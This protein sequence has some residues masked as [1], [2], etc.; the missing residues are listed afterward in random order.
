[1]SRESFFN[2]PA[3]WED[4]KQLVRTHTHFMDQI[5]QLA[6][7]RFDW[8][9]SRTRWGRQNRISLIAVGG[10][11][12]GELLPESDIDLLILLERSHHG[13]SDKIQD[14]IRFLWDL[15]L[16]VGH[17]VRTINECRTQAA[18]DVT[19]L[20]A[21]MESRTLCGDESLRAK[22]DQKIAPSRVWPSRDFFLA[23]RQ[24]QRARHRKS[25]HT[26]YSLEPNIKISPGGLRDI[27]TLGWIARRQYG[28]TTF[29][30]LAAMGVI[31]DEEA[32]ELTEG[33]W[34]LARI[35]F[36]L[37]LL[38]GRDDN[39]LLFEHQQK[40]AAVFGYEDG[41]QLAVEQFMQSYYRAAHRINAISDIL[42][43]YFD[44]ALAAGKRS[45]VKPLNERFQLRGNFLEVTADDVFARHPSA[46]IEMF[47]CV[48][49]DE[50][51]EGIRASTIRLARQSVHLID[52]DF[53]QDPANAELFMQL[54][55]G[56]NHLFTQ[57]RRMGRY[58]ILGAWL[59]E[60]GRVVGQMQFD[61]FHIYTVD[62]HTLQVVRNMRRFRYK[63]NEQEFPIAAHIH[64]RLPRVE[65]LYIAGLYHDIAKGMGGDHSELGVGIA[66]QF[67][68]RHKL[69]TWDTNL[70]CW[71]VLNHL[72]MST[73]AQ[74]RD[75]QD[76]DVIHEFAQ[77]VG[78]Q[79]RLDYLYA[80]TVADITATNPT[81]WNG[82]RASL[83]NQ[84]YLETK[85][86]LRHGLDHQ[87]DRNEYIHDIQ[88]QAINKLAEHQVPRA[89]VIALWNQ[90][91]DDYFLRERVPDIVRQ[92]LA[93]LNHEPG[94]TDEPL[95][96][97]HDDISRHTDTGYTRIFVHTKNRSDLF[98]AIAT[99]IDR[100]NLD[101]V[102]A[103]IATSSAGLTFN[104]F[105]VLEQDGTPVGESMARINK[106][107]STIKAGLSQAGPGQGSSR[108]TPRQ[109]RQFSMK[110]VV[111]F[112][113]DQ[114]LGQTV[115]EVIA[116]D[117][118]GLLAII[119]EQFARF[120][121]GLMTA[122]ITTLGERV[123]DLFY[124]T[125][126]NGL[127]VQDEQLLDDLR[128]SLCEALDRHVSPQQDTAAKPQAQS[129]PEPEDEHNPQHASR[130]QNESIVSAEHLH[131]IERPRP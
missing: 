11:G 53:R 50:T 10:Y 23:K 127:P 84:L 47:T 29:G 48:A 16:E 99:A 114:H 101:I 45:R 82:W 8:Q 86:V 75:I 118:P 43:Q 39:R 108:R 21:M 15:G 25:D 2:G 4:V 123:E 62:A 1:M 131:L 126:A 73:T 97:V 37:H 67:C 95:V 38:Q 32:R 26:E 59:P 102:D 91:D 7:H 81:L 33:K 18:L 14:F 36:A 83:L 12:R 100:L 17:S 90:V 66:R 122:R 70:V 40:L 30:D 125:D 42:L 85:K 109:L 113:Q 106:I 111:S 77:L 58:G 57:L 51:I 41:A 68:E 96:V 31:T 110:T 128:A 34:Q 22:M 117:R 88:E 65:L 89:S 94:E 107:C 112:R 27:Q 105:T 5:L 72:A 28:T 54:L 80:L 87:I 79:V 116:P 46:L 13:Y 120:G 98:V 55:G 130:M 92:T 103:G 69:A 121:L 93:I 52:D 35:R 63:N 76:P 129:D 64:A 60:F 78:D 104:T 44:E 71:L 24:E 6:W 49:S 19:V 56:N 115:V 119:A 61:L 124:V 9:E 3:N 74:R 20:T